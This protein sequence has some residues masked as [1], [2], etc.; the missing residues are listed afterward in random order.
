MLW[1][2][3]L[4][5]LL[6]LIGAVVVA[7]EMATYSTRRDRLIQMAREGNSKAR[8]ALLYLRAPR[9]YLAGSQLAATM[10]TVPMGLLSSK[11]FSTPL[12]SW[13]AKLGMSPAQASQ[14]AFWTATLGLTLL[15]TI[16]MNLLPKRLAFSYADEVAVALAKPAYLWIR[17]T[18]PILTALNWTV[19]QIGR[20]F[21]LRAT[22]KTDVTETDALVM[23]SEG[24]RHGLID[25]RELSIVKNAM[26][27]SDR[28]VEE[29]MTPRNKIVW[30]NV[31][32]EPGGQI[33]QVMKSGRSL[34]PICNGNLDDCQGEI[35]VRA[36]MNDDVDLRRLV[37]SAQELLRVPPSASALHVLTLMRDSHARLALVTDEHGHVLGLVSLNDLV[38]LILGDVRS[39]VN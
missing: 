3:V 38:L 28:Q 22:A 39:L 32:R 37:N 7:A 18:G 2:Y 12:E 27:L 25:D 14:A 5:I 33:A 10:I 19:D 6:T 13:L 31:Q 1:S 30:I 15:L 23:L 26:A 34:V 29:I 35:R 4:Y 11:L 24:R 8:L 36:L 21:G 16:F 9:F 17:A 20:G